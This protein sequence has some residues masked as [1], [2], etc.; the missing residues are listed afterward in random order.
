VI[1]F[2]VLLGAQHARRG[3]YTACTVVPQSAFCETHSPVPTAD[4]WE[5]GCR[6]C[7]WVV[8]GGDA[9]ATSD[10]LS[11]R[12]TARHASLTR[13]SRQRQ[14]SRDGPARPGASHLA[15]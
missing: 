10:V 14:H 3:K 13:K 15:D 1:I 4:W 5:A 7:W 2:F 8:R 9:P 6:R 11:E 12:Y